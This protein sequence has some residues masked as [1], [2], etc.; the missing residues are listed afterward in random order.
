MGNTSR[1]P[2]NFV[3]IDQIK[4]WEPFSR[5]FI[6]LEFIQLFSIDFCQVE[7]ATAE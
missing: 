7:S 1:K 5:I 6:I 2:G 3:K 4:G